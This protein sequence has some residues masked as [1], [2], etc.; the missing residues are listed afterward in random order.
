MPHSLKT[1]NMR[2]SVRKTASGSPWMARVFVV[3]LAILTC[4]CCWLAAS[5]VSD[6]PS[7]NPPAARYVTKNIEDIKVGDRV[8]A[9]VENCIPKT[10]GLRGFPDISNQKMSSGVSDRSTV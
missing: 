3:I 7:V 5:G 8:M 6:P 10:D 1:S 4:R 2:E 9:Y